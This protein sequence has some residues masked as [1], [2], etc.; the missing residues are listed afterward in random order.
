MTPGRRAAVLTLAVL[1][2][3]GSILP[4]IGFG[5]PAAKPPTTAPAAAPTSGRA[6]KQIL[7]DLQATSSELHDAMPLS[8]FFDETV[9]KANADKA[10][11]LLRKMTALLGELR[12]TQKDPDARADLNGQQHEF[13]SFLVAFGDEPTV[14]L[15]KSEGDSPDHQKA[16]EAQS[17]L[18]L[19]RWWRNSRNAPEQLKVLNDYT[20]VVKANPSDPG[21]VQTLGTMMQLGPA[22]DDVL[23]KLIDVVKANM[24]GAAADSLVTAAE[25]TREMHAMIGKPFTVA[26]RTVGGGKFNSDDWKG[27]V[28]L[29]D[30][31]AT[32]C[33]PCVAELPHVKKLYDEQ[34][35]KGL[36]VVGVD[37]DPD[38][39]PV[40]AFTKQRQIPWPQV[41]ETS[42]NDDDQWSPLAKQWH[43]TQ[44][45]TM[46]LIDRKG[47]LRYVDALEGTETKVAALLAEPGPATQP[48]K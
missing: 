18:A 45:P 30:F 34:H 44:I 14:A 35:A 19:G 27:K 37:C 40:I 26:G 21:V 15:L 25:G 47:V 29:V 46:F 3:A 28:V 9:R 36:E 4:M 2:G 10:V 12:D 6:P 43:V 32:W 11:P 5:D 23:G 1:V 17:A 42:Q 31:W 16:L 33:V 39:Q 22:N 24:K 7:A 20:P 8:G 48:A 41:R 38:D 13:Y